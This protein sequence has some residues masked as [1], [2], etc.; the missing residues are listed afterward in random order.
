MCSCFFYILFYSNKMTTNDLLCFLFLFFVH[1][2]YVI[3]TSVEMYSRPFLQTLHSPSLQYSHTSLPRN[4]RISVPPEMASPA[5]SPYH[6]QPIISRISIPPTST[7][8]RQRRPIPLSVIMRL[9][10]PHWGAMSMRHSDMSGDMAPYHPAVPTPREFF[11]KPAPL[12][13]Q[14]PPELRQP[15]IYSDGETCDSSRTEMDF[16]L[17]CLT[18]ALVSIVSSVEPRRYRR[19]ARAAGLCPSHASNVGEPQHAWGRWGGGST[20]PQPHQAAACGGPRGPEP[21]D[22]R[23]G[24]AAP[25]QSRNPPRPEEAGLRGPAAEEC[26]PLPA[27]PVQNHH[28][29]ALSQDGPPPEEGARQ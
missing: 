17:F 24:G 9:Q 20:A 4:T 21:R 5:H 16:C 7:P 10:N 26:L 8:S 6:P 11:R 12:L 25:H 1:V 28:Q 27:Q 14:H 22:P 23:S 3:H 2:C 15:A 18:C 19:G 29:Q 13:L